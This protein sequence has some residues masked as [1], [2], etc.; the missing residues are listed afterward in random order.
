MNITGIPFN[1]RHHNVIDQRDDGATFVEVLDL[2]QGPLRVELASRTGAA[3]ADELVRVLEK[4]LRLA[5][6]PTGTVVAAL[7]VACPSSRITPEDMHSTILLELQS[8][9]QD[10]TASLHR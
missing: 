5:E 4:R 6:M 3:R 2:V 10:I 9:S 1:C 8:A 7:N